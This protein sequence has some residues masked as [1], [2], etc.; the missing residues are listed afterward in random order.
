MSRMTPTS[1]D[2]VV[3]ERTMPAVTPRVVRAVYG[4]VDDQYG[5]VAHTP[6]LSRDE[7]QVLCHAVGIGDPA[8]PIDDALSF[9]AVPGWGLVCTRYA[10]RLD[11]RG[12]LALGS[13]SVA[14]DVA[15]FWAV[16]NDPLRCM[17]PRRQ[18]MSADG[19]RPT[20]PSRCRR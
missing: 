16:R 6:T 8:A 10:T 12:R 19:A 13:D 14:V 1:P 3:R 11:A 5:V 18:A 15:S 7:A 9:L 20:A 4:L 2:R 17:P